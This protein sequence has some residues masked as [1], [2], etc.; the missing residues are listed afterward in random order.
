MQKLAKNL[1]AEELLIEVMA[2]K[3]EGYS[4]KQGLNIPVADR[5]NIK[6][7]FLLSLFGWGRANQ[8]GR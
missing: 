4:A 3:G 2:V 7:I 1:A 8:I 6:I 5:F